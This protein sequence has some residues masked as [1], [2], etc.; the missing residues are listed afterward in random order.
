MKLH[1]VEVCDTESS[2]VG[3][4]AIEKEGENQRMRKNEGV[5]RLRNKQKKN[6]EKQGKRETESERESCLQQVTFLF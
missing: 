3:E 5:S 2:H 1:E 4:K 6:A